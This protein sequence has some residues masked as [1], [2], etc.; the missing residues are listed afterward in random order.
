MIGVI[1]KTYGWMDGGR[2]ECK[3]CLTYI[4]LVL[5]IEP[6]GK[7][8]LYTLHVIQIYCGITSGICDGEHLYT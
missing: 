7:Q 3:V 5:G 8:K 4:C 1:Y 6:H 2:V